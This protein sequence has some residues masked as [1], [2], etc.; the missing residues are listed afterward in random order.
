MKMIFHNIMEDMAIA[1]VDEIFKTFEEDG[2][3][4]RYCTCNQCRTDIICYILNRLRPQYIVSYRGAARVQ[5]RG[6]ETQQQ[7]ADITALIHEGLKRVN[8]N[9]RHN[10]SHSD[11][12]KEVIPSDP[13]QP[14]FYVPTIMGRLFNGDNFAPLADAFVELLWNGEL[15]VMKDGNWHNPYHMIPNA[16][17]AYSFWPAP[18]L[19]GRVGN[20]KIFEYTLRVSA[21]GFETL[22]HFFK[23]PVVSE[24]Q[25][26][27]SFTLERT[28]KLP[29][30]YLFPPG[31]AEQNENQK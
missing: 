3:K 17:G 13:S 22:N 15:I 14:V 20:H 12:K 6:L 25:S 4:D 31:E 24:Y 23:V 30:L 18:A 19:S 27:V 1:R 28:F 7:V 5:W 11:E 8:H 16:E 29:D 2:Y 9:K 21:E 26:E 10:T